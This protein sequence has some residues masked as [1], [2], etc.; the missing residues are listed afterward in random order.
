MTKPTLT[1]EL[2][3]AELGIAYTYA[4]RHPRKACGVGWTRREFVA[5]VAVCICGGCGLVWQGKPPRGA[6]RMPQHPRWS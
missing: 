2:V 5:G 4:T 6:K 1:N 3:R